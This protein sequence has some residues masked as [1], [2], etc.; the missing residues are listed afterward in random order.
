MCVCVFVRSSNCVAILYIRKPKDPKCEH[1]KKNDEPNPNY[2]DLVVVL[3][4]YICCF[5]AA[6]VSALGKE[7]IDFVLVVVGRIFFFFAFRLV[8]FMVFA[9]PAKRPS[10]RRCRRC[11][12]RMSVLTLLISSSRVW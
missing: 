5:A 2:M 4:I 7:E 11:C 9:H 12:C 10:P 1:L 8:R 6:K 3:N